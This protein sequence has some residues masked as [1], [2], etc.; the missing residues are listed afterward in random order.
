MA[1]THL[2]N[3]QR[4]FGVVNLLGIL[5]LYT[6]PGIY[7]TSSNKIVEIAARASRSPKTTVL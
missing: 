2:I 4:R 6:I 3:S 5:P 7:E 1:T